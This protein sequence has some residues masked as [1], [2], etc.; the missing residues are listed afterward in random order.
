MVDLRLDRKLLPA[1]L[2]IIMIILI[3]IH[4]LLVLHVVVVDLLHD[5]DLE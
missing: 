2:L 5:I 1:V 4:V 3:V